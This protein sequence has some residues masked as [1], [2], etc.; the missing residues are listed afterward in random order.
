[1]SKEETVLDTV[2]AL[3]LN[4][5]GMLVLDANNKMR[6]V[7]IQGGVVQFVSKPESKMLVSSIEEGGEGEKDTVRGIVVFSPPE[8]E[9]VQEDELDIED[10][11]E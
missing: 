10:A 2:A 4:P 8:I 6:V 9:D 3:N 5:V 11:K 1:M 7:Q